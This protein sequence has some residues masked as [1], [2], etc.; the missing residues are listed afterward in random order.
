MRYV[1]LTEAKSGMQLAKSLYD[2]NG[3]TL[4]GSHIML[5]NNYIEK[6]TAYGY[7]GI[8]IEDALTQDIEVED[9]ISPQL[10]AEGMEC[11]ERRDIDGCKL[12]AEKLVE[13]IMSKGRISLDMLDL[14]SYDDYTYAHSMNVGV[15]CGV[16]GMEMHMDE[17]EIAQLVM[18]ALL[19]DLGKL[20]IPNEILNKPGRLTQKEYKRMQEHPVMSYE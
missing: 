10:R 7:G 11:I 19:H 12:V 13:E 16:I 8:Y 1:A 17:K 14:R 4:V 5:T 6:L 20:S 3:R 18:A 2:S 9:A 15:L